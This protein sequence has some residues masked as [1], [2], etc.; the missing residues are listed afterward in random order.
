MEVPEWLLAAYP[1]R[2]SWRSLCRCALRLSPGTHSAGLEMES[3]ELGFLV[4][5]VGDE[6]GQEPQLKPG[7]LILEIAAAPL[8]GLEPDDLDAAF[9]RH[10][11]H[12][13]GLLLVDAEE[14][15]RATIERDSEGEC[16]CN[17]A[18]DAE[19]FDKEVLQANTEILEHGS[20]M[21][22]RLCPATKLRE[23]PAATRRLLSEDLGHFAAQ[24]MLRAELHCPEATTA[25]ARLTLCGMPEDVSAAQAEAEEIMRFYDL[26]P[27]EEEAS[28]LEVEG[29]TLKSLPARHRRRRK[30]PESAEGEKAGKMALLEATD[31]YHQ[32]NAEVAQKIAVPSTEEVRLYEYLDHTADVILHSWGKTLE[33]AFEQCCVCFFSYLTD[34]DT[35]SML[36]SVEVQTTGHD[37]TDLLYHLLDEFLFSFST[38]FVVCRRVEVFELDTENLKV[39]ARGYGE[40]FDLQKHPQGTE[41]KAITMHQMKVLTPTNV[42]TEE[43]TML[44]VESSMEGGQLRPDHPFECYVL[45]DI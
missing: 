31:G 32:P 30:A 3:T 2:Q 23:L 11:A 25:S 17:E 10:F 16:P 12:G 15:R 44:R 13:A 40:K 20:V 14:L 29:M 6:P 28:I 34:L 4:E 7:V 36:S 18:D 37:L 43:G 9:G 35:V 8:V 22:L 19:E 41:I 38:E 1:N 5:A 45:V 24:R 39:S 42:T 33:E 27:C 26:L 21:N